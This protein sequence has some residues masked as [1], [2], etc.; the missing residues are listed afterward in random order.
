VDGGIVGPPPTRPGTTRLYLSG[1][2]APEIADLFAG[3]AAEPV[4]LDGPVTA[5]SALKLSYASWAKA[6]QALMLLSRALARANG[7]EEALLGEWERSIPDLPARTDRAAAM[8]AERGWRWSGEMEEIAAFARAAGLPPGFHEAAAELFS[9]VPRGDEET[10][11]QV[12]ALL[13]RP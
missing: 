4:V 1:P 9:R 3:S 5:A 12:L 13:A 11:A 8:A 10:V 6:S 7:V 2:D